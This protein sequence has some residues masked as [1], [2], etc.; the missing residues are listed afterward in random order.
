MPAHSKR[1]QYD[2]SLSSV[3]ETG[4]LT[5]RHTLPIHDVIGLLQEGQRVLNY[6]MAQSV[7]AHA[8]KE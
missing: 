5:A 2:W 6:W 4:A 8:L 7:Q 3:K 1:M